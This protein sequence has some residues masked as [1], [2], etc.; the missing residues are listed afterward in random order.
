M[1][2]TTVSDVKSILNIT[3]P[4]YD[5]R[6]AIF[7][8]QVEEDFLNIRGIDF[9]VDS[10]DIIEYPANANVIAAMM[11]GYQLT[12]TQFGGSGMSD[13]TSESI[14]SYSYTKHSAME[15]YKG[16]PRS[17]VGRIDQWHAPR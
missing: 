2:I 4:T 3:V 10:N 17:I 15:L 12:S 7:I 11:I 9:D 1:A 13:K 16:Y 6:I 5:A 14:G 8:P